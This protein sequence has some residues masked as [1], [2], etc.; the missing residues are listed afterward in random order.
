M[1]K[2]HRVPPKY[3]ITGILLRLGFGA[4]ATVLTKKITP[5]GG[6]PDEL[7]AL[8]TRSSSAATRTIESKYRSKIILIEFLEVDKR[9]S[10]KFYL[11][12]DNESGNE[13]APVLLAPQHY[14]RVTIEGYQSL[15]FGDPTIIA[16][17]KKK[18]RSKS[19][20]EHEE[21]DILW[22]DSDANKLLYKD[23]RRGKVPAKAKDQHNKSTMELKNI[24]MLCVQNILNIVTICSQVD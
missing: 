22:R 4:E 24:Y 1:R 14:V 10:Y 7:Q 3:L 9:L 20:E 18:S 23:L 15:F 12:E 5:E 2:I 17:G 8:V 11:Y 6:L 21:P 13:D 19:K 16:T